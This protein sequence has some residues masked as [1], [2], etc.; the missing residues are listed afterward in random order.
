[1][2][3]FYFQKFEIGILQPTSRGSVKHEYKF[4]TIIAKKDFQVKK[5]SAVE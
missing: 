1:M 4:C 5:K 3:F 2:Y